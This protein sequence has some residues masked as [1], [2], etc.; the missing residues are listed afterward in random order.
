MEKVYDKLAS[1]Y[2]GLELKWFADLR[3]ALGKY[4]PVAG[5]I[6]SP[7][8]AAAFK[9]QV[10]KLQQQVK[11][12]NA[13]L[14]TDE[15]RTI[16]ERLHWLETLRQ[17]PELV[18]EV[19]QRFSLPNFH[20][21]IGSDL[22]AAAVGGPIDDVAPIDDVILGTVVHGTGRT[23]GQTKASLTPNPSFATF[24]ALLEAVN[25]SNNVGRNGPVD[26]TDELER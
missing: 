3:T 9:I 10:A 25:Y 14:S 1:G 17:A 22:L 23:V 5:Y 26:G 18:H 13:N 2:E 4:L 12:L 20:V 16:S 21:Q 24:D 8:L 15:A 7:D 6:G 11:S 19:R